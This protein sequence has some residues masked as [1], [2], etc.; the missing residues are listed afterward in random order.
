VHLQPTLEWYVHLLEKH[1]ELASEREQRFDMLFS[2]SVH[3]VFCMTLDRPF[4]WDDKSDREALLDYAFE[5]LRVTAV[6][7][8]LCEQMNTSR[9]ELIGSVPR[10]RWTGAREKWREHMRQ[11]YNQGQVH[12]SLQAPLGDGRWLDVEGEYICT[13]DREGRVTG[14][15]GLQRDVSVSRATAMEAAQHRERLE[16]AILGADMAVWDMDL[17]ARTIVFD[18]EWL[19]RFGYDVDGPTA[20]SAAWWRAVVHP[21]DVAE[22]SQR[23]ADHLAGETEIYRAEFRMRTALGGWGWVVWGICCR[24][25][26]SVAGHW[27]VTYLCHNPGPGRWHEIGRA[28]V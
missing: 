4:Y 9:D 26:V 22:L 27:I 16:L 21:D 6:N 28:H 17:V 19:A 11:L 3:G 20:R 24:V 12:H 5:H 1:L 13:Y 8:A 18:Q 14:H 25:S 7:D 23:F 15:Y 10:E 2:Q